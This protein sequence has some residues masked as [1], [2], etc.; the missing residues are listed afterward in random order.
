MSWAMAGREPSL[1]VVRTE[2]RH[3]SSGK[4]EY[5]PIDQQTSGKQAKGT[6]AGPFSSKSKEKF[7]QRVTC[8]KQ[9]D[10]DHIRCMSKSFH[11]HCFTTPD[12]DAI[13]FESS[14]AVLPCLYLR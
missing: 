11:N 5:P 7:P 6:D 3:T 13:N 4:Y 8:V 14:S 9:N 1:V 10:A 2:L 12:D